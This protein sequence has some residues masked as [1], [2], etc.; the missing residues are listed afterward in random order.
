MKGGCSDEQRSSDDHCSFAI[1]AEGWRSE[2]AVAV[3]LC[4]TISGLV[5][6]KSVKCSKN[7]IQSTLS[8]VVEIISYTNNPKVQEQF[9]ESQDT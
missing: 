9:T 7:G 5:L 2:G 8:Q 3:T 4:K 6:V 1:F